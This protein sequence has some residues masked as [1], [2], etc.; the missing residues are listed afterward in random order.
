[1]VNKKDLVIVALATF[2]LTAT[3]FMILPTKS[4]PGIGEY[5]PENDL[6]GDGTI[7]IY[8]AI[9]LGGTY[10][11]SGDPTRNITL[12]S[13]VDKYEGVNVTWFNFGT[14]NWGYTVSD[15][16]EGH[17]GGFSRLSVQLVVTQWSVK[18]SPA[19]VNLSI[20]GIRWH[21]QWPSGSFSI[22]PRNIDL[23]F[24]EPAGA[25]YDVSS[26]LTESFVSMSS[27]TEVRAPYYQVLAT[28]ETQVESGWILMDIYVYLRNE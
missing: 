9:N 23:P 13:R 4:N 7:D 5:D 11:T 26:T 22:Y 16:M 27:M 15:L 12:T 18:P 21:I 24:S 1:M 14:P 8:D 2:C 25:T 19:Y 28:L 20:V 10:G 6:N 3:L 17:T